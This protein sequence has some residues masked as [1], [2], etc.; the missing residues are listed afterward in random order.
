MATHPFNS[1]GWSRT[2]AYPYLGFNSYSFLE[3]YPQQQLVRDFVSDLEMY[4]Y[5]TNYFENKT[6]GEKTFLFGITMQNHGSYDYDG[7]GYTPSLNIEGFSKEYSDVEQYLGLINES[8][9][10][11]EY[12]ITFF[13]SYSEDTVILFFGD[14]FPNVDHEFYEELY[15]SSFDTLDEQQ[16]M[17]TVPFFVWANYDIEEQYVELTSLNYLTNYLYEAAD[18]EMPTYNQFLTIAQET[19]PAINSKGYYS[20]SDET[21]KSIDD[22][23][24]IEKEVI[25]KME[26]LQY[27]SIFD[28]NLNE[29]FF[30][31]YIE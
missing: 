10:A 27:N 9:K 16:L 3:D 21:F 4:E 24:A 11:L 28:K 7:E 8:D 14:H 30:K 19:I 12:L 15:G 5:I 22:A 17:Y 13:E 29:Y 2:K 20:L 1:S 31:Q 26:T 25:E 23:A 6:D 18:M